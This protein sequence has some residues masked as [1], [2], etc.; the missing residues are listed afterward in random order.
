MNVGYITDEFSTLSGLAS[1]AYG[2]V[3]TFR[4]VQNQIINSSPTR[5]FDSQLPSDIFQSF[6]GSS[7]YFFNK[8]LSSLLE[9]YQITEEFADYIDEDLGANWLETIKTS[10]L[11]DLSREIN[12]SAKYGNKLEDYLAK[13]LGYLF[14]GY[15]EI[16][17]LTNKVVSDIESDPVLGSDVKFIASIASNNPHTKL[18]SPPPN[19]TVS[20]NENVDLD[21]DFK[22]ISFVTGYLTPQQYYSEIAYPDFNGA[23]SVP[24]SFKDSIL[25]GY[26]GYPSG[27][28]MESVFNPVGAESIRDISTGIASV[29][30]DSDIWNAAS[31]LGQLGDIPGLDQ[32]E[33]DIYEISLIGPRI[34]NL[35]TFDPATMSNG[36]YFDTG[37]LPKIL[38]ADKEDGVPMSYRNFSNTF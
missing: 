17:Q 10:L 24:A 2:S 4:E 20:L 30:S 29:L 35:L 16:T 36:D 5:V 11:P 3:D 38:N 19:T 12:S 31:V 1:V 13:T 25:D 7:D 23:F 22:G 15:P 28:S 27:I 33:R 21:K 14:P 32:G 26:I 34:N 9:E 6:L 37:S 18:D 8:I